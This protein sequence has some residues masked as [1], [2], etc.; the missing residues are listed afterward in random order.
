[1]RSEQIYRMAYLPILGEQT[2]VQIMLSPQ[3]CG[4]RDLEK[5]ENSA[6][7]PR[8]LEKFWGDAADQFRLF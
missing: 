7:S 2:V 1:M 8:R 4:R 3:L 6:Q 5:G